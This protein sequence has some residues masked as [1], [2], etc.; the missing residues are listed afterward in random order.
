ME[1]IV[2][3]LI[4]EC[5]LNVGQPRR[6]MIRKTL[7][8]L[9]EAFGE[10]IRLEK[11]KGN[12]EAEDQPVSFGYVMGYNKAIDEVSLKVKEILEGVGK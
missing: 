12:G 9:L 11:Q 2:L 8:T 10:E 1:N 4:V 7:R 5:D 6:P 3:D